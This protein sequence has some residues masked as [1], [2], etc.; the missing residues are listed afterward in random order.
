MLLSELIKSKYFSKLP[1]FTKPFILSCCA[2]L[3][4]FLCFLITLIY[5]LRPPKL[6]V[7]TVG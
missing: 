7:P 3:F 2:E 5:R 6:N 4:L 1:I